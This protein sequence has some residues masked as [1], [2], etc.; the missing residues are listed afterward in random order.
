MPQHHGVAAWNEYSISRAK[1]GKLA[2][3]AYAVG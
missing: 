2:A 1:L 3:S